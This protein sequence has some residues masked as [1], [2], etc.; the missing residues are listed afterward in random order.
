[1][2]ENTGNKAARGSFGRIIDLE[3]A[4]VETCNKLQVCIMALEGCCEAAT[5]K[6]EASLLFGIL[7][8]LEDT[9]AYCDGVV[10]NGHEEA[11]KPGGGAE[12][13]ESE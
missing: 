9:A 8:V 1:M 3:A 10:S 5:S 7:H 13:R 6:D 11:G 2:G 12:W 4:L